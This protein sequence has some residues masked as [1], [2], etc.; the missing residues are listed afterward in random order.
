MLDQLKPNWTHCQFIS[1]LLKQMKTKKK[2][3]HT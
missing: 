3:M 2:L 1:M